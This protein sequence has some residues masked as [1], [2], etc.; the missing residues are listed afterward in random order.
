MKLVVVGFGQCGNRIA[1]EFSRLDSRARSRRRISILAD[2]F[3]VNTD[4]ADLSILSTAAFALVRI[5]SGTLT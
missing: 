4:S 3:A 5:S 2:A 1:E